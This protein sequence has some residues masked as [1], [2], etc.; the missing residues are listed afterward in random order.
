MRGGRKHLKFLYLL[1]DADESG[2]LLITF[3]IFVPISVGIGIKENFI[4]IKY[5]SH[6]SPH[7]VPCDIVFNVLCALFVSYVT[8][9]SW[10]QIPF[11]NTR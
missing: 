8:A 5:I 1:R 9:I 3:H 6:I 4:H 10:S 11:V 2:K 7:G